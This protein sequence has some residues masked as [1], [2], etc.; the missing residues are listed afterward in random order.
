MECI[1]ISNTH[2]YTY[3]YHDSP[4]MSFSLRTEAPGGILHNTIW[5][6]GPGKGGG[7]Y[8]RYLY[9]RNITGI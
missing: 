1:T 8:T 2:T 4:S 6:Y 5:A 3:I 7:T 9:M